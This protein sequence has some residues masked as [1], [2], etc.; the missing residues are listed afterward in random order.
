MHPATRKLV[1]NEREAETVRTIFDLY[2]SGFGYGKI[3][4]ELNAQGKR[5]KLDRPFGKNSLHDILCNPKYSG[6]Y[7]F[8]RAAA[9]DADG[10]RNNHQSKDDGSV[11]RHKGGVPAIV[12]PEVFAQARE[13]MAANRHQPGK[14]RA[15][16]AYLLSGLVFC[17]ECQKKGL[18]HSMM[19]NVKFSGQAKTKHVT[20]RCG[21]RER[22][23]DCANPEIRREYLEDFVLAEL[24]KN[25]FSEKAIPRLVER[26]RAFQR[27]RA[28]P[29]SPTCA[30]S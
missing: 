15:K 21:N 25:V 29:R 16:E 18:R 20:Y 7:V 19:G 27:E 12:D 13:K 3:I 24:E 23:K 2:I 10:R 6:M 22:K 11:I 8:N 5:T 30:G 4:D 9:K 14:Y 1:V 26:L 17:G 28:P